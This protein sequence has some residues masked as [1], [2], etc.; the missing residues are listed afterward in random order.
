[1]GSR[2]S[3]SESH[4]EQAQG[5]WKSVTWPEEVKAVA[6][7]PNQLLVRLPA[8]VCGG[9]LLLTFAISPLLVPGS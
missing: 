1:M 6:I 9:Q 8:V 7:V 3:E 2:G 4:S 5:D